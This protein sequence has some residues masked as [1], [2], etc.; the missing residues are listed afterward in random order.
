MESLTRPYPVTPSM[1]AL[2]TLVPFYIVISEINRG[3]ALHEPT[4]VLDRLIPLQPAWALVYGCLYLFLILLPVLI[5]HQQEQIRRTVLAYLTVWIVAYVC[6]VTYPTAAPR[7]IEVVGDGFAVWGLRLLYDADPP[8][9]CFPSLHVAHSFVS[10]LT[11]YRVHRRVGLV[12]IAC[13]SLVAVS[14]LF[15]K[16]HYVLDVIAGAL[17]AGGAGGVFLRQ[18]PRGAVCERQYHAAPA[19]AVGAL[20]IIA[21][22]VACFWM[23]YLLGSAF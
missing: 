2:V 12:A 4:L 16:Q 18:G 15:T 5:V 22:G 13:A 10:A 8:R 23:A 9:N 14:T 3:R 6:F 21:L 7:P 19:L 17:L 11:C 1:V 20:A